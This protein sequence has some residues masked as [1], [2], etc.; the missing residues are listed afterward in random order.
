MTQGG[1][2]V[3]GLLWLSLAVAEELPRRVDMDTDTHRHS[4]MQVQARYMR[5]CGAQAVP[6]QGKEPPQSHHLADGSPLHSEWHLR[7]FFANQQ[8][9]S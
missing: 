1:G 9:Q 7:L 6:T 2:L 8:N 4:A 5:A 3:C